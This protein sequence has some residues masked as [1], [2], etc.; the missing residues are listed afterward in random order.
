MLGAGKNAWGGQR[1][2]GESLPGE[3]MLY[4]RALLALRHLPRLAEGAPPVSALFK[5][6]ICD[7]QFLNPSL[8]PLAGGG[9]CDTT[10]NESA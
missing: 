10:V 4:D 2:S 6:S 9:V 8:L 1:V 3:N 5:F 7:F